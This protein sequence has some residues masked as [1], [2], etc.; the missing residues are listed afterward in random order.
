VLGKKED[1]SSLEIQVSPN[2]CGSYLPIGSILYPIKC[3][4]AIFDCFDRTCCKFHLTHKLLK[5]ES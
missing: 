2:Q 5:K 1:F 4:F 3:I